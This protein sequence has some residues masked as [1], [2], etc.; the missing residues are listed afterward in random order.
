MPEF[1]CAM[2]ERTPQYKGRRKGLLTKETVPLQLIIRRTLSLFTPG[3]QCKL[4]TVDTHLF[5]AISLF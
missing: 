2:N 3:K 5:R 1:K 4:V